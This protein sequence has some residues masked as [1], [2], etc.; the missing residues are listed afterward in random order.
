MN[1]TQ[2]CQES[3]EQ[4]VAQV[5]TVQESFSSISPA[6][7]A[8]HDE[9]ERIRRFP[10]AC[11]LCLPHCAVMVLTHAFQIAAAGLCAITS[12]CLFVAWKRLPK[13][14]CRASCWKMYGIF[15]VFV[16]TGCILCAATWAFK[17]VETSRLINV[18]LAFDN[19]SP[20]SLDMLPDL[21]TNFQQAAAAA[22]YFCVLYSLEFTL[23]IGAKFMVR[24]CLV[25][26]NLC[27]VAALFNE[28]QCGLQVLMR[29]L[30]FLKRDGNDLLNKWSHVIQRCALGL[31]VSV[32]S[33]SIISHCIAA[34]HFVKSAAYCGDASDAF[35]SGNFPEGLGMYKQA[36]D[37][38]SYATKAAS[39]QQVRSPPQFVSRLLF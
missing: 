7:G 23:I 5:K 34:S 24:Y 21:F 20:P 3:L 12:A 31:I 28:T 8:A 32:N 25:T 29:M 38:A 13:H 15:C 1:W 26:C 17:M 16:C 4:P 22:A 36:S 19:Q 37:E 35:A 39:V 30:E 18:T 6:E 14:T 9:S 11:T 33:C 27:R 2:V 10:C